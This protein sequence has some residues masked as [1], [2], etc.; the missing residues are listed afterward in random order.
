MQVFEPFIDSNLL[1]GAVGPL[2]FEII[3]HRLQTE[4]GVGATFER[5][6]VNTARWV[7]CADRKHLDDFEKA[8]FQR[9][10]RDVDG[11]LVFIAD[12]RVILNLVQDKWPKVAF[13]STREHGQTLSA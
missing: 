2:Q 9:L 5:A 10:A 1:L 4:Y 8:N 6:G 13:H 12:S 11:N 3:A 7:S